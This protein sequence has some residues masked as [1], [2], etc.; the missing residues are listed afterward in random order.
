[1]NPS[2][3]PAPS[4]P[5]LSAARAWPSL[6][7]GGGEGEIPQPENHNDRLAA[8]RDRAERHRK[9]ARLLSGVQSRRIVGRGRGHSY[10]LLGSVSE[11][12][13]GR[14][15][16]RPRAHALASTSAMA[17]RDQINSQ[18]GRIALRPRHVSVQ[19]V[20]RVTDSLPRGFMQP[21]SR[22]DVSQRFLTRS[23]SRHYEVN[24]L[25]EV[26]RRGLHGRCPGVAQPRLA[27]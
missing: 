17:R 15:G 9:A 20:L 18:R 8:D 1:M 3:A 27:T 23:L 26:V 13:V 11:K 5:P 7:V 6:P 4:R 12:M 16:L 21:A 2:R 10:L 25:T 22:P 19:Q 24:D 14:C